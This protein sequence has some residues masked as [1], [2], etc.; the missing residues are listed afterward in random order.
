[1]ARNLL[2]VYSAPWPGMACPPTILWS[3]C[4]IGR[5]KMMHIEDFFFICVGTQRQ[6]C[7]RLFSLWLCLSASETKFD[8]PSLTRLVCFHTCLLILPP[9]I[10]RSRSPPPPGNN[11]RW[12]VWGGEM[13]RRSWDGCDMREMLYLRFSA[14]KNSRKGLIAAVFLNKEGFN[15]WGPRPFF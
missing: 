5:L 1:M 7:C 14:M 9:S 6:H 10:T 13:P 2:G 3:C 11:M 12:S 15:S 8:F 4:W